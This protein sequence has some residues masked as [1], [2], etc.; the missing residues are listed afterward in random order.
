MY[1][2]DRSIPF[3]TVLVQ[4][5]TSVRQGRKVWARLTV[6]QILTATLSQIPPSSLLTANPTAKPPQ[7]HGRRW[8]SWNGYVSVAR[9]SRPGAVA[10]RAV[11]CAILCAQPSSQKTGARSLKGARPI[12]MIIKYLGVLYVQSSDL[13]YI[14]TYYIKSVTTSW[15]DGSKITH[16]YLKHF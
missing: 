5:R 8:W 9:R 2:L 7:R 6:G 4:P 12:G 11:A 3:L 16:F 15:T 10:P 1:L 14:L 13:F